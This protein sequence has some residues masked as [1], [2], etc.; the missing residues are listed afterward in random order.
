MAQETKNSVKKK[1]QLNHVWKITSKLNFEFLLLK[2][3]PGETNKSPLV[4]KEPNEVMRE[5]RTHLK[6][7]GFFLLLKQRQ[8]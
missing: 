5:E 8:N 2:A 1:E 6:C 4:M 7:L 3:Q